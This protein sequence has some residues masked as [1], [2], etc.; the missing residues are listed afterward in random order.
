MSDG[1]RGAFA[2]FREADGPFLAAG[3][4]FFF[5][6]SLIP[7]VLLAVSTLG[8]VLTT[9]E[10]AREVIGQLTRNVPVYKRDFAAAL[11]GIVERRAASGVVG[12]LV[13]VAFATPLFGAARLVMHRMLGVKAGGNFLKNLLVDAGMVLV[14]SV[15]LFGATA[16]TWIVQWFQIFVLEPVEVPG[17]WIQAMT[18]GLSVGLSAMMFYLGYRH[19]PRREPRAV[20]ALAGALVATLLWEIAK[21]VLRIYVREVGLYGEVYGPFGVL[22]AFAMFVY[23]SALVFVFGAAIVA[24]VD[25]RR[26]V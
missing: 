18:L 25:L 1:P 14:L 17:A 22:V 21:E 24:S 12:T 3:L 15:L 7:I 2:R 19:V 16:L 5:L 8:W 20:A 11:T 6:L 26:R 4:A 9:E 23:Y 13:L 10:A